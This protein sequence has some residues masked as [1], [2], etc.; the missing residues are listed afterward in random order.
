MAS[1]Q[2]PTKTFDA[3]A[4]K[5]TAERGARISTMLDRW[6]SEDV[7]S[8]PEWDVEELAPTT[9]RRSTADHDKQ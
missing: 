6:D 9:F 4:R 2:R 8:E 5:E 3:T 1:P 7:S